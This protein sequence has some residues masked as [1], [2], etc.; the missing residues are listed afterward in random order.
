[1]GHVAAQIFKRAIERNNKK[2]CCCCSCNHNIKPKRYTVPWPNNKDMW[3]VWDGI[4]EIKL[5][6]NIPS[7]EAAER[8][9][10]TLEEV[11]P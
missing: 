10:A 2:S 6:D 5:I 4:A 1:M 9:A 11:M 7:R 3:Y 8:I